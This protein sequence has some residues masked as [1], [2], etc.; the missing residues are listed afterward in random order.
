MRRVDGGDLVTFT[1]R[2]NM[3][4]IC[5]YMYIY[6]GQLGTEN[7]M[8]LADKPSA[9]G[10]WGRFD[11]IHTSGKPCSSSAAGARD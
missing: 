7:S 5:P 6:V 1:N 11:H 9:Q 8:G 10:S 4:H 3:V 2:L